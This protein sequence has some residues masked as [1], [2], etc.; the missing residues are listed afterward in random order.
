MAADRAIGAVAVAAVDPTR[1]LS[2]RTA[3]GSRPR[4]RGGDRRRGAPDSCAQ[5]PGGGIGAGTALA[6][7]RID[8]RYMNIERRSSS[9]IWP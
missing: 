4:D 1:A 3:D 9:V 2:H 5:P 7:G 6:I 8:C